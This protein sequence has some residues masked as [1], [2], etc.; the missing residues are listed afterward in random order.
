[1]GLFT[2]RGGT[3]GSLVNA[4]GIAAV[5]AQFPDSAKLFLDG[6]PE[7][8]GRKID[9]LINSHHHGDHTSGNSV[10]Q[11]ETKAIVA[12]ENVPALQKAAAAINQND[13]DKS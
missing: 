13:A 7:R 12:Q 6:L 3:I 8:R 10:F 1:M 11:P 9:L 5:D 4:D 2:C